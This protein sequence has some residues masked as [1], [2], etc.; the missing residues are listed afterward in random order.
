MNAIVSGVSRGSDVLQQ[1]T[2]ATGEQSDGIG[3]VMWRSPSWT[4]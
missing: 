3:Q 4:V 2:A 1:I